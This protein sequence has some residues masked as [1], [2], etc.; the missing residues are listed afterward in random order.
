MSTSR[1]DTGD[2]DATPR[3]GTTMNTQALPPTHTVSLRPLLVG[4]AGAAFAVA[5]GFGVA[6]V[7]LDEPTASTEAPAT[8]PTAPGDQFGD[9]TDREVRELM[10]R[11]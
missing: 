9:G 1:D 4:L 7:V 11:R 8:I 3:E 6:T 5:A 10:H 2:N